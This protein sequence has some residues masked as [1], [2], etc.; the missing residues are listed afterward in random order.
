MPSLAGAR[1]ERA[2]VYPLAVIEP[3]VLMG[4]EMNER[5]RPVDRSV[6]LE[7]GPGDEMVAAEGQQK[8]AGLENLCSLALDRCR[9]LLMVAV[10]E[11][12]V[13]IVDDAHRFEQIAAERILRVVVEDRRSPAN[14]LRTEPGPR[15]VGNCSIEGNSPDDSVGASHILCEFAS[16][17][18]QRP[19]VGRVACGASRLARSEGVVDRGRWHVVSPLTS[20]ERDLIGYSSRKC[21]PFVVLRDGG[22]HPL[23]IPLHG[24]VMLTL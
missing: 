18:G 20:S 9:R 8:S 1:D 23:V 15:P 10:V 11:Q 13:A 16:H 17:E 7:K 5:K 19:G 21:D 2:V 3:G 22:C 6:G 24:R 14:S 4:V 12:A